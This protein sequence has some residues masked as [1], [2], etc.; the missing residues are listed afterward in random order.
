L[1]FKS[2]PPFTKMGLSMIVG[3]EANYIRY[4]VCA[5]GSECDD[6]MGFQVARSIRFQESLSATEFTAALGA[7][8]HG[9]ANSQVARVIP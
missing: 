4:T 3:A 1:L 8:E 9:F 2:L 5:F 6:V 7:C